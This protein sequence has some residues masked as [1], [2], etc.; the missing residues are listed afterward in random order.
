MATEVQRSLFSGT[1]DAREKRPQGTDMRSSNTSRSPAAVLLALCLASLPSLAGCGSSATTATAPATLARCAVAT[2]PMDASAPAQGASGLLVIKTERECAWTAVSEASWLAI[3]GSAGGQGDGTIEYTVAANADP[4]TRRGTIAVNDQ[5]PAISQAAADCVI[6]L[7]A[8]SATFSLTGGSGT[9]DLQ[10]SSPL[11]TWTA[12]SDAQWIVVRSGA[13]GTGGG[14]VGFD[15][16]ATS[17]PARTGNLLIAGQ[18]FTITQAEGCSAS[19]TPDNTNVPAAGGAGSVSITAPA[20]CPWT[21]TSNADWITV[22]S[23]ASGTGNGTVQF[24]V[25]STTAARVGTLT[26]AGKTFTVNQTPAC[27]ISIGSATSN[28]GAAAGTGTVSVIAANGCTWTAIASDPWITITSGNAGS[29]NGTVAFS[30]GANPAGARTGSIIIS[31]LVHTVNQAGSCSYTL[32]PASQSIPASGGAGSLAVTASAGCTWSASSNAPWVTFG[33]GA[34]GTGNGSIAFTVAANTG[35]PRTATITAGNQT[36][37]I[38]QASGCV[39]T[40]QP[41]T[42]NVAGAGG[43]GTVNVS[44]AAGCTWTA[45]SQS[46]WISITS[47][48]SGTGAGTVNYTVAAN[49]GAARTGTLTI[50]GVTFTINQASTCNF[51]IDRT[52][53]TVRKQGDKLRVDVTAS[54]GCAWTATSPV[55]WVRVTSGATGSGNGKVELE[56]DRNDGDP[57]TASVTIAGLTF[58]ITQEGR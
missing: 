50:A 21:A 16:A 25:A 9:V 56:V 55:S 36:A 30:V 7:S 22:T 11:C 44:V 33:N 52:A 49:T 5:H 17:G 58:R 13:S 37:T 40:I 19:I 42:Q 35:P 15:V 27:A 41:T 38:Q 34:S 3:K 12:S 54:A 24:A 46:Q 10:T 18:R 43:S 28:L 48:A 6:R 53:E 47:G 1:L 31:G 8:S 29:G 26:I 45:A 32:A 2:S 20:G 39:Y 14:R 4:V 57:R 51:A 23:A